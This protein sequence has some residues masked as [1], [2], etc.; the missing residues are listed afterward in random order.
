[1]ALCTQEK[2]Y[3]LAI[4]T[5]IHGVKG[6]R[7]MSPSFASRNGSIHA[8]KLSLEAQMERNFMLLEGEVGH[9]AY[10]KKL[11]ACA[12]HLCSW[13]A[14]GDR[15]M[16]PSFAVETVRFMLPDCLWKR[17]CNV[18]PCCWKAKL[19]TLH[20][21]KNYLLALFT[22][23]CGADGERETSP[24]FA[25]RKRVESCCQSVARSANGT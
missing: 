13:R 23:V 24:S 16:S 20:T 18:I 19:G 5:F 6:N 12:F 2:N 22:F 3:L 17:K 14:E 15:A 1:M 11:P 10:G 7:A 9:F 4:F 8:S 25:N 21:G